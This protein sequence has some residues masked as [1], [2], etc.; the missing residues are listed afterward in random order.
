[1]D[2]RSFCIDKM[3]TFLSWIVANIEFVI[4]A[5]L[6]LFFGIISM[7]AFPDAAFGEKMGLLLFVLAF[8]AGPLLVMDRSFVGCF[9]LFVLGLGL[10]AVLILAFVGEIGFL[11]PI[12]AVGLLSLCVAVSVGVYSA[13]NME[14]VVSRRLLYR[15]SNVDMFNHTMKYALNRFMVTF[16]FISWMLFYFIAFVL[17]ATAG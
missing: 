11:V 6:C 7:C 1:M 17:M 14:E 3:R 10:Y 13:H 16:V 15:S 9:V 12:V 4:S 5:F 8:A 2:F